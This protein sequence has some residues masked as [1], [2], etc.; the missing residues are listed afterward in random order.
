MPFCSRFWPGAA[1]GMKLQRCGVSLAEAPVTKPRCCARLV[2][3]RADC[4][5]V[6]KGLHLAIGREKGPLGLLN[7]PSGKKGR[8]KLPIER[9]EKAVAPVKAVELF[10]KVRAAGIK[11]RTSALGSLL[12]S[13]AAL[14]P[15][16]KAAV[17]A[18]CNPTSMPKIGASGARTMPRILP[19][20][21]TTDTETWAR[22]SSGW[23]MAARARLMILK[24]SSST[25]LTSVALSAVPTSAASLPAMAG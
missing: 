7:W 23:R 6:E 15:E 22:L 3:I 5:P 1:S 24:A 25:A 17:R 21:S 10:R 2:R 9:E 8:D 14:A 13:D 19:W 16:K 18:F 20:V 12:R 11:L 4:R